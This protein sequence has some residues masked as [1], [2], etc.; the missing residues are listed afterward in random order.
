MSHPKAIIYLSKRHVIRR[1]Q[2]IRELA[3]F[4]FGN[5]G[6]RFRLGFGK[7]RNIIRQFGQIEIS[8]REFVKTISFGIRDETKYRSGIQESDFV[9]DSGKDEISFVNS[10]KS[11]YLS[12]I[13]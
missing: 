12:L 11:K 13:H 4:P 7:R 10:G 3:F 2:G 8:V 9:Q 6:K 1:P 5:S